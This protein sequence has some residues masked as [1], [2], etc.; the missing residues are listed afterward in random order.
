M[1]HCD[2]CE[3]TVNEKFRIRNIGKGCPIN[4]VT[5]FFLVCFFYKKM[6]KRRVFSLF[7]FRFIVDTAREVLSIRP[8]EM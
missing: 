7:F 5:L 4:T 1:I 3:E 2:M 6:K 8:Y